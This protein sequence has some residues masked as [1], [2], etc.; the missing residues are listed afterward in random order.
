M[1][2]PEAYGSSLVKD[3]ILAA[4]VT[5][6]T[7]AAMLDPSPTPSGQGSN[8]CGGRDNA[9]SLTLYAT[10]ETPLNSDLFLLFTLYLI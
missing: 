5:Y 7:A 6:T 2:P 8:P 9:G 4:V 1:A 10:A 3:Q